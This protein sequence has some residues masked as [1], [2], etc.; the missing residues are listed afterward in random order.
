MSKTLITAKLID[1]TL[2]AQGSNDKGDWQRHSLLFSQP[3]ADLS[4]SVSV[5]ECDT[6]ATPPKVGETVRVVIEDRKRVVGQQVYV[7][8]IATRFIPVD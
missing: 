4:G 8:S 3:D 5:I 7:N 2:E 6:F 1:A